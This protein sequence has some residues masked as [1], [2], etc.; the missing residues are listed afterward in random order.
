MAIAQVDRIAEQARVV[1]PCVE[2]YWQRAR[3]MEA[4]RG[5]VKNQ[6]SD[7]DAHPVCAEIA[8]AQD[9]AAVGY[10]DDVHSLQKS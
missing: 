6:L 3:G 9:A 7:R 2:H 4:S 10:D 5:N 1:G 8:Q